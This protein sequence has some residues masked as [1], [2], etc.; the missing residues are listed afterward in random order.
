MRKLLALACVLSMGGCQF[1][2][3]TKDG[4]VNAPSTFWD[5]LRSV[6]MYVFDLL[7]GLASNYVTGLF[8]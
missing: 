4:I 3:D 1:M 6:F 7:V 5:S 8:K 2:N